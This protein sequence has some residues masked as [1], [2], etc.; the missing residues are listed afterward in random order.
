MYLKQVV[1]PSRVL[2]DQRGFFGL[3]MQDFAA[4]IVLFMVLSWVLDGSSVA[5][6][7]LPLSVLL[8]VGLS[9]IRLSTRRHIIRDAIVYILTRE[10]LYDPQS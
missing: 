8:L 5:L 3:G 6:I 7:S 2:N 9:P 4:A 1:Q 10:A